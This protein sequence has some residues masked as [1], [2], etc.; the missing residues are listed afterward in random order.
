MNGAKTA[1]KVSSAIQIA[2]ALARLLLNV[3]IITCA[4][5]ERGATIGSGSRASRGGASPGDIARVAVSLL[6]AHPWIRDRIADVGKKEGD[7]PQDAGDERGAQDHL[8]IARVDRVDG[9]LA[10]AG[11]AEDRL[12]HDRASDQSREQVR[13]YGDQR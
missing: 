13:R 12:D 2:P 10:H 8:A 3:S 5:N 1:P 6:I 7:E 4:E 9:E 11:N